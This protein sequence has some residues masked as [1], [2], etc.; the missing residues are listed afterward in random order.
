MS[1]TIE[2]MFLVQS[3]YYLSRIGI[4]IQAM[5][6]LSAEGYRHYH[7][8]DVST[9]TRMMSLLSCVKYSKPLNCMS[10]TIRAVFLVQYHHYQ[11]GVGIIIQAMSALSSE[12]CRPYHPSNVGLIIRAMSSLLSGRC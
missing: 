5:S 6:A 4:I 8:S 9:T 10:K 11:S 3:H 1:K 2:A 7:P 12:Q